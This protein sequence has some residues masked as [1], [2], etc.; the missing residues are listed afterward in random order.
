L[1]EPPPLFEASPQPARLR[2][3]KVRRAGGRSRQAVDE[4]AECMEVSVAESGKHCRFILLR[5][6]MRLFRIAA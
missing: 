5:C 4:N 1:I 6:Q 3:P 2:T